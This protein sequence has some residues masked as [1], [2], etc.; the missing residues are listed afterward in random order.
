MK[1]LKYLLV[2]CIAAIFSTGCKKFL[3]YQPKGTIDGDQLNTAENVEKM[4]IAAYASL[5]N[6]HWTVPYE[7]MW[8]YGDSR[9]DDSYKGG[10]SLSDGNGYN[11]YQLFSYVQPTLNDANL[12]WQALYAGISRTNDAL[13]RLDM[14]SDQ[15]LPLK[16]QRQA[17]MRFIRA[18]Y[19]FQLKILFKHIPYF[20]ETISKDSLPLVSNVLYTDAEL[21]DKITDEFRFAVAHLPETQADAGRPTK[22]A[23]EAY[24]AKVLL[25]QAYEQNDQNE[26]VNINTDKL[27]EV[28]QLAQA[29]DPHYQLE[30]DYSKNYLWAYDNSNTETIWAIERTIDDGTPNGRVDMS[31]SANYPMN[32]EYGCCWFHIPSQSLVN[33]YKTDANGLPDFDHYNDA[34]MTSSSDFLTYDVDPRLD[35]TVA[36]PG[37]PFKY[38]PTFIY[39]LSWARTP[40]LY[41]PY[42]SKKEAQVPDCPC[43]KKVGPFVGSSKNT[44][45]IRLADVLLWEAEA[46]IE[47]GQPDDALPIINRIRAR[48][49]NST[50]ELNDINGNPVSNYHIDIYKPGVNCTWTPEFAL[51]AFRWER[52][53]EFAMEGFRFFDLVRWGIAAET[54]NAYFAKEVQKWDYLKDAHFTK[55]RDEYLPIP[56]QQINL[57]RGLYQQNPGW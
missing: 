13:R 45:I 22:W 54:I 14:I 3:D 15:E 24:L 29:I 34:D 57:T 41:G 43:L 16:V 30:D 23:A 37:H 32:Q 28:V 12:M 27:K 36:I 38:D 47:L 33:A 4:V 55:G 5:G 25:Y 53:M 18:H 8:M 49:A 39:Q 6:D 10:G 19:Y 9:T 11:N 46:L 7:Q 56:T 40:Q 48:A 35:H 26:V 17:E 31:N 44:V 50:A 2:F 42:T 52:R 20:D 1:N 51:K 21:W